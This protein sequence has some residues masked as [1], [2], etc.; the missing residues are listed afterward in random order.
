LLPLQKA[1]AHVLAIEILD[2]AHCVETWHLHEAEA[3]RSTGVAILDQ[4]DRLDRAVLRE[5]CADGVL[6]GGE[7]QIAHIDLAH[8]ISSLMHACS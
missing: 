4:G 2:G 8:G 1:S 3:T 5:Q 6:V 7:G